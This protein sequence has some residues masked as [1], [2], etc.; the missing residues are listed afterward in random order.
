MGARHT[1]ALYVH[2]HSFVHRLPAEVKLVAIF[3][4]VVSVAVTPREAVWAFALDAVVLASVTRV[5]RVPAR[6]VLA[7]MT[8]ILPFIA[9]A[10][11]IPFIATGERVEVLGLRV[12]S[13]GLWAAWNVFAKATLGSAA[14]ITLAATTEV[15]KMLQG[16]QRLGVP[17]PFTA[18]AG[19]M[20]RYLELVAGNL[21]R[22]R[23]AM[24]ARGYDP[25]WLW[26]TR[27]LAAS[28]GALFI[29]SY[30]R[31]ERV[32]AAMLARGYTGSMPTLDERRPTAR[33]WVVAAALPTPAA[34]CAAAAILGS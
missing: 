12:S 21:R 27:P 22:M 26:Q 31:G 1:H 14:S 4:F 7:R 30:E 19:F 6:F 11:A 10:F 3:A 20:V 16:M 2:E 5:A 24:T 33:E 13:V 8:V 15:P 17:E 32:H 25:R 34:L 29:R 28:A 23:T 18:I 9:F